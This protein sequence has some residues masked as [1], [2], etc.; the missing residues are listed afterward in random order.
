ME[1]IGYLQQ[2]EGIQ[3]EVKPAYIGSRLVSDSMS[4][5]FP[6]ERSRPE[7]PPRH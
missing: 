7:R 3:L 5:G 2:A 6:A 1:I 4:G